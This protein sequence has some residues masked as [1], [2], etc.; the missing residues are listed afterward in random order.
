MEKKQANS[1]AIMSA[2]DAAWLR[3][4]SRVMQMLKPVEGENRDR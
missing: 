4:K 3:R 1:E 2:W